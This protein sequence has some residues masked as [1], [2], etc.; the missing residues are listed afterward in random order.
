MQRFYS[1]SPLTEVARTPEQTLK[2]FHMAVYFW[3][4]NNAILHYYFIGL[5]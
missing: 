5:G 4:Q 1:V 2:S 3:E